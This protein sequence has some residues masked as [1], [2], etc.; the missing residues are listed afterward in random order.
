MRRSMMQT[1]LDALCTQMRLHNA[2]LRLSPES[3]VIGRYYPQTCEQRGLDGGNLHVDFSGPGYAFTNVSKKL[4]F[5]MA[6]GADYTYDFQVAKDACDVYAYFK[7]TQNASSDFR[8]LRIEQQ[9]AAFL[10]QVS[11]VADTFG[12]QLVSQRVR[13]GFTVIRDEAGNQQ[14][15]L[16]LVPVGKKPDRPFVVEPDGKVLYETD[17]VEIHQHQRDFLGPI[18]VP[19]GKM[20]IYL[21]ASVDGVDAVD[22]LLLGRAEGDASLRAYLDYPAIGPLVGAPIQ[23]DVLR[24][25]AELRRAFVVP[26][27]EYFLVFD[28]SAAA[29]PVSPAGG[30][31]DDRAAVVK[32]LA[33]V[34]DAP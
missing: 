7:P 20:A 16:G 32:Y 18:E 33:Q 14:P 21:T 25:G 28:N 19:S 13:D 4:T 17:R 22:V 27:G 29:G 30:P 12:K 10:N 26:K 1:G 5:T 3:P 23:G 9:V 15:V 31:L 24:R 34:G 11:P 2:P 6:G 8:V